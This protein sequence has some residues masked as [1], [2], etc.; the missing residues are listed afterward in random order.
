MYLNTHA[1]FIWEKNLSNQSLSTVH[2]FL[3]TWNSLKHKFVKSFALNKKC[4]L[5]NFLINIFINATKS[6]YYDFLIL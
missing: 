6:W 4:C 5:Y 3:F 2:S 1:F